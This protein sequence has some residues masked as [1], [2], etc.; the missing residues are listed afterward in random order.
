MNPVMHVLRYSSYYIST[1]PRPGS[2]Q[3]LEVYGY[4]NG[5]F[6]SLYVLVQGAIRRLCAS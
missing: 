4:M 1:R 6:S 3:T 2:Y 5:A